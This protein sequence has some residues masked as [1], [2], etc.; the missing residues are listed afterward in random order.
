LG[1]IRSLVANKGVRTL[2]VLR[3]ENAQ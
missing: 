1:L 2:A 3:F